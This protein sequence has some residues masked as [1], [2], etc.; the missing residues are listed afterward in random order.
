MG[1]M[2]DEPLIDD[3]ELDDFDWD[4]CLA[5][6]TV[7]KVPPAAMEAGARALARYNCEQ[8]DNDPDR[9]RAYFTDEARAACLA[10][11]ENW[12]GMFT[13]LGD[14]DYPR[15]LKPHDALILPLTEKPN[16]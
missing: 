16:D 6:L 9:W 12:P 10:M 8:W 3:S 1:I 13:C 11:L 15:K 4:A 5:M 14:E 2:S 7:D